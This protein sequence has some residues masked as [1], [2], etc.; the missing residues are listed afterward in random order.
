[1]PVSESHDA[2]IRKAVDGDEESLE[3]LIEST[4]DDIYNLALRFLWN[5]SD[6]EDATQ[7]I[8][9]RIIT[10]LANFR[11]ECNFSTWV[12]RIAT[13]Y[14]INTKKRALEQ[15]ELTFEVFEAGIKAGLTPGTRVTFPEADR[16]LL[17]Q[18]LKVSCTH[19][20][21]LCLDRENRL[22]YI[23]SAI[24]RVKSQEGAF[25]MDMT[26]E[27]YRK[28]WSRI[29][30]KMRNFM[31][32][33][34]GLVNKNKTCSCHRRIE[35]AIENRRINPEHLLF[36]N[37]PAGE[38]RFIT[39]CINE[40]EHFDAAAAAFAGNPFYL[41]PESIHAKIATLLCSRKYRIIEDLS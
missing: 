25:I 31:E 36:T 35:V 40:M 21:L 39:D 2:W 23:L 37:R 38:N 18:E 27:V 20:M 29:R 15:Q 5:P 24:F 1:M 8:L 6:A 34:C 17:A 3:K 30:E 19:A 41:A 16:D 13:N 4:Q 9:I 12:Y 11:R 26:P 22:I 33:N 14:L 32:N 10:H 7:E 28:R